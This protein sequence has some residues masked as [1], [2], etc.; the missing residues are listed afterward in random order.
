MYIDLKNA[1]SSRLEVSNNASIVERVINTYNYAA[2]HFS[3]VPDYYKPSREWI[4]I[5]AEHLNETIA[6]LESRDTERVRGMYANFFRHKCSSGLHGLHFKMTEVYMN[7]SYSP[8]EEELRV[9]LETV[10]LYAEQFLL[11]CPNIS[12]KVLFSPNIG[13]PYG[14]EIVT[15][16]ERYFVRPCAEYHYCYANRI[17]ML[18]EEN[19]SKT[20]FEIGGGFGGMAYFL[21]REVRDLKYIAIDLL[22]NIALQ[23]FYLMSAFPEKQFLF[24]DD[25]NYLRR[26]QTNDFDVALLPN[27]CIDDI[28]NDSITLSYNS[29]S[30]AE[31]GWDAINNYLKNICRITSTYFYHVNHTVWAINADEFN[32]DPKKFE[33]MFR[34]PTMWSR[35]P[36]NVVQIDHHDY[37]YKRRNED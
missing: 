31:M 8:S 35:D 9:Y 36:K 16:S 7:P 37:L 17:R 10:K 13:N 34:F 2:L 20:V 3:S 21:I 28:P 4:A 27:F 29:Y 14:Y 23:S 19:R 26:L 1:F 12:P 11:S 24:Y 32:V 25:P 6:N 15:E 18:L 30:L 5:F 33:L 22:E